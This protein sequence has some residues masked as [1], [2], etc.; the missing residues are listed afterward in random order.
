MPDERSR[1]RLYGTGP[2][3]GCQALRGD[4]IQR[5]RRLP[6]TPPCP[7]PLF[8][9]KRPPSLPET[10]DHRPS[11]PATS[12]R[13]DPACPPPRT[14]PPFQALQGQAEGAPANCRVDPLIE[15]PAVIVHFL[16]HLG[17]PTD[18]PEAQPGRRRCHPSTAHLALETRPTDSTSTI[19]L[20]LPSDARQH[21]RRTSRYSHLVLTSALRAGILDRMCSVGRQSA[22]EGGVNPPVEARSQAK[23]WSTR[24]HERVLAG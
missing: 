13:R 23:S 11:P 19:P 15:D 7:P 22:C 12:G 24:S 9:L 5:L 14:S 16:G 17:L 6:L 10:P 21:I 20:D 4:D 1:S 18:I 8:L 2:R 3:P